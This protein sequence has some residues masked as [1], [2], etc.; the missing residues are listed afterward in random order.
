MV[1]NILSPVT[2]VLVWQA[3][4]YVTQWHRR[5]PSQWVGKGGDPGAV[6]P[7]AARRRG[8]GDQVYWCLVT[9]EK[10]TSRQTTGSAVKVEQAYIKNGVVS[11][12]TTDK[13]AQLGVP[14]HS[15]LSYI[16]KEGWGP[17]VI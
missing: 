10:L 9:E 2:H 12:V 3:Q 5:V 11:L 13:D 15:F 14:Y 8:E 1:V 16:E 4:T 6:I 7:E 17:R